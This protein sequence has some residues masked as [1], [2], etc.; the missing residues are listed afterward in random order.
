MRKQIATLIALAGLAVTAQ[1]QAT[2]LNWNNAAGGSAATTTNWNPTQAPTSADDLTFNLASSYTV[3]YSATTVSSRTHTYRQG[4]VTLSCTSPH[5]ISNGV[6]VGDLSG[7][8]ATMT[9][10]TGTVN[11]GG[12]FIVGDASG[13]TGTLNVN[14]DDADLILTG[15]TTD[16][17]VGNNGDAAMSIT[18]GGLVVVPDQFIL[19]SNATSSPVLTVS[20]ALNLAP[21]TRSTLN[22]TGT[23]TSR[24]GQGGDATVSIASGALAQFAGDVVVCNGAAS[25]S[26]VTIGGMALVSRATLDVDGDLLL[27]R[28][29]SA[30]V[31]A[32]VASVTVNNGGSL[33]VGDLLSVGGDPDGGSATL[34]TNTGSIV[35]ATSLQRGAGGVLDFNG[36]TIDING[37]VFSNTNSATVL[38]IGG[39]DRPVVTLRNGAQASLTQLV[40]TESLVVGGRSASAELADFDVRSGADLFATGIVVLADGAGDEGGM[41]INGDGS[42][43]TMP[44]GDFLTVGRSGTGRYEAELGA[45]VDLG[46]VQIGL[47]AGS[48]GLVLFENPGTTAT[49]STVR[50]GGGENLAGGAG[51]FM[52]NQGAACTVPG[53]TTVWPAGTLRVVAASLDANAIEVNGS[54]ELALGGQITAQFLLVDGGDITAHPDL[55]GGEVFLNATTT[56]TN[57]ATLTAVLGDI[58]VGNP[59]SPIGFGSATSSLITCGPNRVTLLD[60]NAAQVGDCTLAGGELVAV[61]GI[62]LANGSAVSGNGAIT[63]AVTAPAGSS[64][65]ATGL[66]IVFQDLVTNNGA[67]MSGTFFAFSGN[68]GYLGAGTIGARVRVD[69]GSTVT[70]TGDLTMG[71]A[72]STTGIVIRG[73]LRANSHTVT[74]LDSDVVLID[75]LGDTAI[76]EVEGGTIA[77]G[78][79]Q[80]T[81][82]DVLRGRGTI[83][84]PTFSA[85]GIIN[86]GDLI[87]GAGTGRLTFTGPYQQNNF[88]TLN[89]DIGDPT[90]GI[91]HDRIVSNAAVDVDGTLNVSLFGGYVPFVGAVYDIVI[92]TSRTGTFDVE[93]APGFSV[94]YLSDRVRL[95]F[96]GFPCEP[97]VNCD[98][99]VNGF[100]I[101]CMEQT[102]NGDN[103]CFCLSNEDF[104]NDGALNGFDIEAV[105]Q[106]VNGAPC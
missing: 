104:N 95:V 28:N 58:T 26:S 31:A 94:T 15:A 8:V 64:I 47:N 49:C 25:V 93:N 96:T 23:S 56:I 18:G 61:N 46:N 66:G 19:G 87:T 69:A 91:N 22:V 92:G 57:N 11:C 30:G 37:G 75:G 86:P 40:G 5:T 70:A 53:E 98:G 29:V 9:L 2:I 35:Q 84:A 10:T 82:D 102:V 81:S 41:I 42:T 20:G 63:G 105:E 52:I 103:A 6:T 65:T 3:T 78:N 71:N 27:G 36:G 89:I 76:A 73:T 50:V 99:A 32:G 77:A 38:A 4:T 106:A 68:G 48:D 1:S 67:A 7:D 43:M 21:F 72:A 13:S 85:A 51:T 59:S 100:D 55:A 74:L 14:D 24:L 62:A 88:S 17:T 45:D 79:L 80:I 101:E 12:P 34:Q 90:E 97:D 54:L 39:P 16:L 83:Q 44:P 60:A 33:L